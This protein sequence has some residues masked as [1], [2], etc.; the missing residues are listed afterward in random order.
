MFDLTEIIHQHEG[1]TSE[2]KRDLSSPD[3]LM[4]TLVAF[5]NGA[6]GGLLIGVEDG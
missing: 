5:A 4:R 2:F 3:K 6:G 1:K